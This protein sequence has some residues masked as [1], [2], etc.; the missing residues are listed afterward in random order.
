L[1]G[2]FAQ[3]IIDGAVQREEV[4]ALGPGRMYFNR[5]SYGAYGSTES[6][7]RRLSGIVVQLLLWYPE[8]PSQKELNFI[9]GL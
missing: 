6:L 5:G 2:E 3:A 8:F 9:V 4:G 1:R 7:F